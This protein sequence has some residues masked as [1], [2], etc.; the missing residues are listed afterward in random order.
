[1]PFSAIGLLAQTMSFSNNMFHPN[2]Y[3][4]DETQTPQPPWRLSSLSD[5]LGTNRTRRREHPHPGEGITTD[6]SGNYDAGKSNNYAPNQVLVTNPQGVVGAMNGAWPLFFYMP[7]IVL[8]TDTGD[9]AYNGTNFEIDLYQMYYDQFNVTTPASTATSPAATV[10]L[11]V[12]AKA[13]LDYFV[14]YFDNAV[15]TSVQITNDGKLR[16]NLVN[17]A[18]PD[19]T[20][21]TF[22]NIVFRRR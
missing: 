14:T 15:F 4:Q 16:Y 22:M 1:M 21:K 20:D 13:D 11:P 9:P 3:T 8:P 6:T 5:S 18:S 12:V 17:P 2:S 7:C 10:N 19:V